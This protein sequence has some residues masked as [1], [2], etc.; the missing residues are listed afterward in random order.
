MRIS[1]FMEN[2]AEAARQ[3]GVTVPELL[4]RLHREG[5]E[6][7]YC[8]HRWIA[9]GVVSML[10]AAGLV[11][12]G[13]WENLQLHELSEAE[14]DQAVASLVDD[15]A[16]YGCKHVLITPGLFHN[17]TKPQNVTREETAQREGDI[18][19][20]IA[21]MAR[22]K[23]YGDSRGVA[24]TMEDY[25]VFL[26][27]IVF[28]EV[29]RR[30][31]EEI[32]GLQCSFDTGNFVPCDGD[33]MT[34]FAYYKDKI[35]TLHLKDRVENDDQGGIEK[36]PYITESGRKYYAAAVGSGDMH[37]PEIVARMKAAGYEGAGIIELFSCSDITNKLIRSIHW[38][39]ENA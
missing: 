17:W 31:F 2:I 38:M 26:S 21:A 11:L 6:T 9:Q 14:A 18:R 36:Y 7:V 39:K 22:A 3:D 16:R 32:P 12:E 29:L 4:E 15:A 23:A 37:I 5:L 10:E 8:N 25:D 13:L 30:F 27:P 35:A 1:A 34:E 33:V 19:R 28:P 24:V 20:M